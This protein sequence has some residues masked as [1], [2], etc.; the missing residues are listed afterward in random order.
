MLTPA[1]GTHHRQHDGLSLVRRSNA[2][3]SATTSL[4][5]IALALLPPQ[6]A[7]AQVAGSMTPPPV[8]QAVDDN[9]VE[10]QTG[11]IV[12]TIRSIAIG[13]GGP[14]S[15]GYDWSTDSS[16]QQDVIGYVSVVGVNPQ[17][18][19]LNTLAVVLG[20]SSETF[21]GASGATSF[22]Q[23]QGRSSTLTY[24]PGNDSYTYTRTDGA[25]AIFTRNLISGGPVSDGYGITSLAYPAG[26]ALSYYYA[27]HPTVVNG[28]TVRYF[29]VQAVTSN[30][31]YQL[32]L[33]Y[34]GHT[35]VG[36]VVFNMNSETCDPSASA[37]TLS[38]SWPSLTWDGPNGNL[39]DAT[40]RAVHWTS[41][42]SQTIISYPSGRTL[43]YNLMGDGSGR[44]MSFN[45]GKGTWSY[46]YPGPGG[47]ASLIFN[48]DN[49]A[50]RQ[51]TWSLSTGLIA[52]DWPAGT[53]AGLVIGYTY[54]DKKRVTKVTKSN[55][56]GTTSEVDYAYD[57]RGNLSQT[58]QVS[59]TPGTPT[60]VVVNAH[61][62][63][64]CTN[65][66][67]CNQPDYLIDARGNRTDYAYDP[68]HGGITSVT[69]PAGIN[70]VRPQKRFSYAAISASYRNG[71][72]A[73]ISGSPLYLLTS[74]SECATGP[75][76]AGTADE[77]RMAA[78]YSPS[79]AL[80]PTVITMS[81]G[82]GA[83]QASTS[84][85]YYGT[86][87]VKTEDGPLPGTGD[88]A[89]YYYDAARRKIGEIDP[90]PDGVGPLARP[91]T[92]LTYNSDGN[93][94]TS[95]EGTATGIADA[96]MSTFQSLEQTV[97]TYDGQGRVSLVAHSGQGSTTNET[98]YSYTNAGVLQCGAVRMNPAVFASLPASACSQGTNGSYG[99]DRITRYAYDP[100]FRVTSV[101]T[102]VGTAAE[103]VEASNTYDG[104]G[105]L[106][107]V[108]DA[109]GNR[110][111]YAYDG[112]SRLTRMSYPSPTTAGQVSSTDYEAYGYDPNGN[113]TS[114]RKRDNST[115]TFQF[116]ALDQ[117]TSKIVPASASGASGY[118]TVQG[119]DN[120]GLVLYARFGSAAGP[121]VT[122]TFDAFGRQTSETTNM[123]G[124]NRTLTSQY[125]SSG[126]R[127]LLSSNQNYTLGY[128]YDA[129]GRVTTIHESAA[130]G[131]P[132]LFF[133]YDQL[134]R[135]NWLGEGLGG[136]YTATAYSYDGASRLQTQT[137]DLAGTVSDQ[138]LSFSYNPA[139]Q[140]VQRTRTNSGWEY[141]EAVQ[142]TKNYTINGLNQYQTA[143][144]A[145][146]A[147]DA[148]GNLNWDGSNTYRY[149]AENRLVSVTGGTNVSL[150]YDPLGR[151]WQYAGPQSGTLRFVYDRDQ[152]TLEYD[153]SG[154]VQRT[155]GYG[156]GGDEPLVWYEATS[157][158]MRRFIH[159]DHQG[160]AVAVTDEVG[161]SLAV[162]K[163]DDWGVPSSGNWGRFQYTGQAYLPDLGLYDYKARIYASRIGRFLQTDPVGYADNMNLYTYVGNDP[164]NFRD[165]TGEL[166]LCWEV[167][168]PAP[169]TSSPDPDG[170][171]TSHG[172]SYSQMCVDIDDSSHGTVGFDPAD[173]ILASAAT[174]PQAS[175]CR[176][177]GRVQRMLVTGYENGPR[178]TGKK[179]GDRGYG[180][181]ADQTMAGPG[182]I[183]APHGYD[184]GTRMYVPGY[185]Y[186]VVHDRGG[187][188][189][190]SHIDVW[191]GS[192]DE[193]VRWGAPHVDVEICNR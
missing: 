124:V 172:G 36:A 122:N 161:N 190:G 84:I 191:F 67:T 167:Y 99:A 16:L 179:P 94:S 178:S 145:A 105:R 144:A 59:T 176:N 76:C 45:D 101:T 74:T 182:T 92:R 6:V 160:S 142:G 112:L 40:G 108:S 91:A 169:A 71:S 125:D 19:S 63:D 9:G 56:A 75:S 126:N 130:A 77:V 24:N 41:N 148:N 150:A 78:T 98:Q 64:T 61:Y 119:Y 183:A 88:T 102:G 12:R 43:T 134:G 87:D 146:F 158:P 80:M 49:P 28:S 32:R 2:C 111:G 152:L 151:L 184:F 79:D 116:D 38:G 69:R 121:G 149:D 42:S 141:T 147:Y 70:G 72:G 120:R 62:P 109:N 132:I 34:S 127:T 193:A 22:T 17:N 47:G 46:Q 25:V 30:L 129:L 156:P 73:T 27:Y 1:I 133:T 117:M 55:G 103:R 154:N 37:C 90:D 136:A 33:S 54:D 83:L 66:K 65:V 189:R 51:V 138:T 68:G 85:T 93:L 95:E 10:L 23:D 96:D 115:V 13:S 104:L 163:Y 114:L 48:P 175:H 29:D 186:G 118:T 135:R 11:R 8:F 21:S 180:Q 39:I 7:H 165:P 157:A 60:D 58:R 188:I 35:V 131:T 18:P 174:R 31:G 181:S 86:G 166:R 50:P 44:V 139:S 128:D 5:A 171:P 52:N 100:Y 137:H 143:G 185:G 110:T 155:Y 164:L 140:I 107:F 81:S 106:T 15:L 170:V 97:T 53:G 123:D 168:N 159:S 26:Q 153:A 14:G 113:M 4:G 177:G 57:A 187:S 20:G 173:L 162:D 82:E 3:L 192:V 89:R